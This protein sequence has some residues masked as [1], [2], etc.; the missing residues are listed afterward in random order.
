MNKLKH[1]VIGYL[2]VFSMAFLP[3]QSAWAMTIMLSSKVISSVPHEVLCQP[4]AQVMDASYDAH[5]ATVLSGIMHPADHTG[6]QA[7]GMDCADNHCS[8]CAHVA[9]L[10]PS[11][12]SPFS[13]D[14]REG[15]SA[16]SDVFLD[17]LASSEMPIPIHS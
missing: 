13:D 7:N 10:L 8:I 11:E 16:A 15:F 12:L 5:Q 2:L 4:A 1:K 17:Y 9:Y 14:L 6:D 3:V